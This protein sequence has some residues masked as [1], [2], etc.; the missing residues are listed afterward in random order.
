[1]FRLH[2]LQDRSKLLFPFIF[3]FLFACTPKEDHL[4]SAPPNIVIVITDDQGI[5]DLGIND[6]PIISTP[7]IDKLAGMSAS[8]KRFYVS[9]VCAPTRANLMTGRYNYRT[10]AIDTY[11]GRAMMDPEEHTVAEI[12]SENG[13]RT[14]LFGKWHLGDCYPM[15]PHDQGFQEAVYHLGGGLAQ[16]SEPLENNRRYTNPILYN[17]GEAYQA[18]GY[19]T[20]I[21]FSEALDYMES[22]IEEEEPFFAY[23]ATNAP[24][25]P[26]HDVPESLR[27]KYAAMDL[28]QLMRNKPSDMDQAKDRLARIFAMVENIDQNVGR[29]MSKLEEWQVKNN[30]IVIFMVDN[31]PNSMRYVMDLRGMKSNVHEGGIRSPFFFH[32]PEQVKAGN[33]SDRI[34]AHID[35]MPT[36]LEAAGINAPGNLDGKSMLPLLKGNSNGWEDRN[37]FIQTHRGDQ[38]ILYHHF[39]ALSQDWK[40]VHP[41]GFGKQEMPEDVPYE[42]YKIAED[43]G[44][45]HNLYQ[46]DHPQAIALKTAYEQWFKDVSSTRE[47]N[48]A[49]PR[50]VIGNEKEKSTHLT[51]Q[52]WERTLGGGWGEQG[53]WYVEI[54]K[55]G[56]YRF[57]FILTEAIGTGS[58]G[59]MVGDQR[60]SFDT[61]KGESTFTS[62]AVELSTGDKEIIAFIGDDENKGPYQLII[63]QAFE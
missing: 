51:K 31:G 34:A 3:L 60:F 52:D 17:K 59:V 24:H 29:L 1:M 44:E 45:E 35:I 7:N 47:D 15:R 56:K 37:I 38:P 25:G 33:T 30:T 32:W 28:E 6:N 41:S 48:Y 23:I 61:P 9:P 58:V 53:K 39:A 16:P 19:C 43:P 13:Y 4:P 57:E 46:D 62:E 8:M 2:C 50:I 54:E 5:G 21:Y 11:V 55:A 20:D 42:L 27:E 26:Y 40:L 14:G 18:E 12:L 63:H 49:K 36:L 22:A 10:R